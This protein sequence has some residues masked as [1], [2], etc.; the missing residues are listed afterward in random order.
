VNTDRD[1]DRV[2]L[3]AADTGETM[4]ISRR[5][6]REVAVERSAHVFVVDSA[7]ETLR[8]LRREHAHN[9]MTVHSITNAAPIEI[10]T[11]VVPTLGGGN[12]HERRVRAAQARRSGR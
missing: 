10:T 4:E 8:R 7:E 5:I 9:Q 12:R 6:A 3:V 1:D 2:V 11:N